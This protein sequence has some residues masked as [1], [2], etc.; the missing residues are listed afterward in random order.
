MAPPPLQKVCKVFERGRLSLDFGC[1]P[2]AVAGVLMILRGWFVSSTDDVSSRNGHVVVRAEPG[3][4]STVRL[5][6]ALTNLDDV[7][8]R[9]AD[10][11]AD[12]AVLGLR[13]RDEL[14]SSTFP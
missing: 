7:A 5:I 14:G 2:G 11:A 3:Q 1:G 8:V 10:V 13:L 4:A 9:I 6:C 12:L